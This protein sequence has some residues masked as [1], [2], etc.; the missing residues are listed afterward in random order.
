[1]KRKEAEEL[2]LKALKLT[3]EVNDPKGAGQDLTYL[4]NLKFKDAKYD[5][6][7]NYFSEAAVCFKETNSWSSL[8]QFNMTVARM[9]ILVGRFDEF[10]RY[11]KDAR[12]IARDLGD[13]K[14]IMEAIRAMEKLKDEIDKK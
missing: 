14:P 8:I 2:Y 11:L 7:E 3:Q 4:G 1:G 10:D 12:E 13:P 9:Q 5:E 6:A